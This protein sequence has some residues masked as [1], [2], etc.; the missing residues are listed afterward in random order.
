MQGNPYREYRIKI[1]LNARHYIII[2]D[3]KGEIHPH[4]WE[5][6]LRIRFMH[7]RFIEFRA[8]EKGISAYLAPY[9]N[10]V[11]N[12]MA[13]FDAIIPT[14]ENMTDYFSRDFSRIIREVGGVLTEIEASET[15]TRSYILCLPEMERTM[16]EDER[17][18][19][20]SELM[21][22]VLDDVLKIEE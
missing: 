13:P 1:Y 5:F 22:R 20:L 4:T 17:E 14:I 9:Q 18:Q 3:Q 11:M 10:T 15:P 7:S 12:E 21:D 8:F 16:Q 6:S 2:N 19:V